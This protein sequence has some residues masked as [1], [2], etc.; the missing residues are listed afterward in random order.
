M[1]ATQRYFKLVGVL[2]YGEINS[3]VCQKDT[4]RAFLIHINKNSC[5]FK[6]HV[7]QIYKSFAFIFSLN[8][9][10]V[11]VW[12]HAIATQNIKCQRE[13]QV[14]QSKAGKWHLASEIFTH[15]K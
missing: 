5:F 7:T 6:L 12:G 15:V 14:C 10:V 9:T 3:T 13:T 2:G 1:S 8:L 4:F 11:C